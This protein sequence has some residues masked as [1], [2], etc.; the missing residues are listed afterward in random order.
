MRKIVQTFFG[1][2]ALSLLI[3]A[4]APAQR[5]MAQETIKVALLD[6]SSMSGHMMG[7]GGQG[8]GGPGYGGMG[9]G[10][11]G[12]GMMGPGGWGPGMMGPG[13][14]GMM[15]GGMMGMM[16]IRPTKSS[17]KAGKIRFEVVNFSTSVVH[18]MEIV[19]VDNFNTPFG[20]D[21]QTGKAVVDKS[22]E[23]GEVEDIAP[24]GTK[25]LETTLP[26]GNYLLL[27]NLPGHYGSGM[28]TPFVVTP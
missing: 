16:S 8:Y 22:K 26:A 12:P 17:V 4:G 13:M 5:A 19:A 21:Y 18:E 27:C 1:I 6:M 3:L 25:V 7:F 10:G 14:M 24:G 9:W 23:K 11:R 28:V 15:G 2:F 20:Y